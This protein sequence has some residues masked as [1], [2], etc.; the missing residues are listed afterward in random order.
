MKKT[1]SLVIINFCEALVNSNLSCFIEIWLTFACNVHMLMLMFWPKNFEKSQHIWVAKIKLFVHH[2][3]CI[4][5]NDE[6]ILKFF[7]CFRFCYVLGEGS[8]MLM[9]PDNSYGHIYVTS[10]GTLQIRGVQKE[11]AG[12]YVCTA[13]SVAG[14]AT[15]RAFLQ[16]TSIDDIPPPIIQIGPANQTL[17][18]GSMAMLPCRAIG[19]PPSRIRWY[20]D[21]MP[22]QTNQRLIIVQSGLKIDSTYRNVPFNLCVYVPVYLNFNNQSSRR[23]TNVRHGPVYL[24]CFIGKWWNILVSLIIGRYFSLAFNFFPFSF[25]LPTFFVFIFSY[26]FFIFFYFDDFCFRDHFLFLF[27]W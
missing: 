24:Y 22:L 10:Q 14:S 26:L 19:N 4:Q 20:K 23:F 5:S 21:G 11:D 17:P 1:L 2:W 6:Q 9:F 15:I 16:V 27:L 25:F 18:I 8:Q 12:Y 13:L 7:H 3:N